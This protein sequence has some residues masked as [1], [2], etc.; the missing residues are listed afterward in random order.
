MCN[1]HLPTTICILC[2]HKKKQTWLF[3]PEIC[4]SIVSAWSWYYHYLHYL[5][6]AIY[7]FQACCIIITNECHNRHVCNSSEGTKVSFLL[8]EIIYGKSPIFFL[9]VINTFF[10]G[11]NINSGTRIVT[12]PRSIFWPNKITKSCMDRDCVTRRVPWSIINWSI[13]FFVY[14]GQHTF[15]IITKNGMTWEIENWETWNFAYAFF[16]WFVCTFIYYIKTFFFLPPS[17][18]K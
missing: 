7:N 4:Y 18:Q 17:P 5:G 3:L 6:D 10:F 8:K 13:N 16:N 1:L 2:V 15:Y 12:W 14:D 9:P 11:Q